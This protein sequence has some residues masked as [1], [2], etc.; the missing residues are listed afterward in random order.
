MELQARIWY[1][2]DRLEEARSEALGAAK[3]YE[4]LWATKDLEGCRKLL[5]DIQ[6]G[7]N[8][9]VTSGQPGSNREFL[10]MAQLPARTDFPF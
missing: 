5:R 2:Q 7:L 1:K 9:Q 4:G 6:N 8:D 10:Q 3:V